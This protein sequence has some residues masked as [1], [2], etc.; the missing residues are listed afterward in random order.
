MGSWGQENGS[1]ICLERAKEDYM[2]ITVS[3]RAVDELKKA[4]GTREADGGPE[5]VRVLVQ[6]QC[7]CGAAHFAMGFDE[8]QDDDNK[9]DLGGVT[10]LVDPDSAP[11]LEN[12][13]MDY[14]DDLMGQGFRI[15]A[16]GGGCGCGGHGHGGHHHH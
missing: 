1:L 12:A 4:A 15:N 2:N 6:S 16:P 9:I 5:T 14:S 11:F 7:G 10:L 13:E 8:P 3:P